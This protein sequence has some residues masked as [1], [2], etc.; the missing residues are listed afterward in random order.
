MSYLMYFDTC[1]API[2]VYKAAMLNKTEAFSKAMLFCM[3]GKPVK[4]SNLKEK[5]ILKL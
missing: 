4:L 3:L 2:C 1:L 5:Q